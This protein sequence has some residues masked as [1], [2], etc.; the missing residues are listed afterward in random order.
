M[1]DVLVNVAA[2]LPEGFD[3]F[4]RIAELVDQDETV[5]VAGRQ[6]YK[7]YQALGHS[8]YTHPLDPGD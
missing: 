3:Q 2:E 1:L 4:E 7:R 8:L 5:K 6:R